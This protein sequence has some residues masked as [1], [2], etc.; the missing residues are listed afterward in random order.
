MLFFK[1]SSAFVRIVSNRQV[2]QKK[3]GMLKY[4]AGFRQREN[5]AVF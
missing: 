4:G 5:G 2:Q 3:N 1:R